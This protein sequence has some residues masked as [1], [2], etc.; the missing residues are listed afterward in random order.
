MPHAINKGKKK[1]WRTEN[2]R[3]SF[4]YNIRFLCAEENRLCYNIFGAK[5]ISGECYINRYYWE[6]RRRVT[7]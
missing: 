2:A 7:T 1:T 3:F 5:K 4:I 6:N